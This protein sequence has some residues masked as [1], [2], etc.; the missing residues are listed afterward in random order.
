MQF[1]TETLSVPK[2]PSEP[3]QGTVIVS[4]QWVGETG[5]GSSAER[6]PHTPT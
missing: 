5:I 6:D 1:L 2:I 4:G 3:S